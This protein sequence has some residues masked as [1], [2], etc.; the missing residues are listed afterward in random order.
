M[1]QNRIIRRVL[2]WW[3]LLR[4]PLTLGVRIIAKN[5]L[6]HVLL[7]RHTYVSGWHLPGGG[8]ELGETL[9][10]AAEKELW[11]ETGFRPATSPMRL[12]SFHYNL[13]A[14]PRDHVALYECSSV[15]EGRAF[16][17]NKEIAEIGF[18]SWDQLPQGTTKGT[19]AR[20]AEVF[21][22]IEPS[23]NW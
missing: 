16:A 23:Q 15:V 22:D 13:N 5:D 6:G 19:R 4:R 2:H 18:F 8:V 14:S 7:V 11:E 9:L 21:D 12:V 10:Q 20:I 3:F 17:P 1:A